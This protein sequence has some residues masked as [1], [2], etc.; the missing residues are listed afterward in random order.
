MPRI[1]IVEDN[2]TIRDCL[3][4]FLNLEGFQV[5]A[6]AEG[7]VALR[8]VSENPAEV[9][10][11]LVFLDLYTE[12]LSA[13]AFVQ[14]LTSLAHRLQRRLPKVCV[15]SGAT[16][17]EMNTRLLNADNFFQ[18]PFDIPELIRYAKQACE[19]ERHTV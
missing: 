7:G 12:A 10:P 1:W 5:N 6:Y 17:I 13:Y 8:N 16:D 11:E 14:G 18:K 9:W 15:V 19:W 3:T 2:D 4:A